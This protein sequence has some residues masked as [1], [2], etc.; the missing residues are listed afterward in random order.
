MRLRNKLAVLLFVFAQPAYYFCFAAEQCLFQGQVNADSVNIRADSTSGAEIICKID[1]KETLE[2]VSELYDWYK[3]RLP[4]YA[5]SFIKKDFVKFGE[6]KSAKILKENVNIRLRSNL[7]SPIL[8]RVNKDESV[9]VLQDAG[10]WYKIEPVH[11]SFGWVHKNFV[12]KIEE[13]KIK[14]TQGEKD[15]AAKDEIT[16]EGIIKPKNITRVGTHKIISQDNK[17]YL[18]KSS[19]VDLVF[20]NR[21]RVKIIGKLEDPALKNPII[22]VRKIEALN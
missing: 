13:K 4:R 16:V 22:E 7:S 5:P 6:G 3:I 11:N 15:E 8:G 14:V 12:H 10:E 2:V 21:R 1:K 20:F 18:L 19:K 17:L 9:K